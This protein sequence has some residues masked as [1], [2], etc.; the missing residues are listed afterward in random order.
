MKTTLVALAALLVNLSAAVLAADDALRA[1]FADPPQ[2]AR[3]RTWWHWMNGNITEDGIAKDLTWMKCIGLGGVQNFDA[4]LATPQV[5]DHR[6]VYMTPE[7]QHAFRSAVQLADQ[8]GLEFAIASSPG[9]SETGGPW[10]KPADGMKKLVWSETLVRGGTHFKA[11]LAAPPSVSGPFQGIASVDELAGLA[12]GSAHASPSAYADVAVLA[13]PVA[14]IPD[15][16]HPQA[17]S[18]DGKPLDAAAL[19]D[20]RPDTS[21]EIDPG[22]AEAPGVIML[23]YSAPQTI[24]AAT[25]LILHA[26]AMFSDAAFRPELEAQIDGQWRGVAQFALENVPTTVSFAPI[27]ASRFRLVLSPNTK[28]ETVPLAGVPGIVPFSLFPQPT[29]HAPVRIAEL[30]LY[31][32]PKVDHFEEKA[33]FAIA[34]DYYALGSEPTDDAGVAPEKVIDLTGRLAADGTL[35]WTPPRGRWRV[36]RF[37]WSLTGTTNHPATAE[38]TGLEVDKYDADA[39]RRYLETYLDMYRLAVGDV[40]MGSRGLRAIVT[41]S[42]EVGPSNWTPRLIERFRSL[43]GYDPTAWLPVLSGEVIGSRK[44]SEAF[45]YDFR[46]TLADLHASEHYGTVAMVAHEHGLKVYGEALE[47]GRPTLGD[48]IA[49]RSHTDVPMSALWTYP[50]DG[51][52]RPTFLGDMKGAASVAHLYG[53]NLVAAESMTSALSPWAFAP[54]DLRRIIDLEFAQGVNRPVIHTS[55]HQPVDDKIPGLSLAIFGQYFTRHETWAELARPWIDYIAR[56]SLLLQQGRNVAD[57]AYFYGEE[58]PITALYAPAPLT[59]TP[60]HYQWDFVNREALQQQLRVED[61]VLAAPSGAR[62]RVLYLGGTS[63]FMTIPVLRRIAALAMAGATIVGDAPQESPSLADDR[64][65][66]ATLVHKLWSGGA[67]TEVGSGRVIAGHELEHALASIG[68]APDFR[69][70]TPETDSDVRFVHRAL[71]DGEIYFVD[72]RLNRAEHIEAQFRVSGRRPEVWHADGGA[73]EPVSYHVEGGSCVVPLDLAAEESV[74]LVFR[75]PSQEASAAIERPR[76]AS[77][78]ELKGPWQLSFQPG[79]GAPAATR[80][81]ALHPLSEDTQPGIRYFSGIATYETRFRMPA[82]LK[83]GSALQLDLGRVGDV[84]EVWVNDQRVSIAWKPPYRV[85]ISTAVTSGENRLR[86]RVADLWV[87][88]LIGDAQPGAQ[89]ITYTSMPTYLPSA[90]LR[91]SGLMGPVLI[92]SSRTGPN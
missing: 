89:K 32:E 12:G 24:R 39:V 3:P 70:S 76:F 42:T 78:L 61:G 82:G 71:P 25:L 20:D 40:G 67:I 85:D 80:Y 74:F 68:V 53:Q 41:D 46:Q 83:A 8:E 64:G 11:R 17:T 50:R 10:V 37:G 4:N 55:V 14:M 81:E 69:Y 2:S 38:A 62:Y 47:D 87:N 77:V 35:D 19:D 59:D 1:G 63:R 31:T 92:L 29:A 23:S 5:V 9:W 18:S 13:V 86:V 52:P 72:N 66:F 26:H 49:M 65:E 54:A 34:R 7:W 36:L 73:I 45:L 88:R 91:P 16:V 79:R 56:T 57:V 58:M 6:L 84:A 48:D 27:T 21:V 15:P 51:Q 60:V 43:R 90:P 22:T 44:R 75:T 28:P 33:G 30:H